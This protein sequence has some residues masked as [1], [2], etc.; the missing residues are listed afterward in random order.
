MCLVYSSS[1]LQASS[2]HTASGE[3]EEEEEDKNRPAEL[4]QLMDTLRRLRP[5]PPSVTAVVDGCNANGETTD[6]CTETETADD[7]PPPPDGKTSD[8]DDMETRLR[9]Y[10]DE[11]FEQLERRLE[12]RLEEL[13]IARFQSKAQ[14]TIEHD[15]QL[16]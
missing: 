12:K 8:D 2:G 7:E 11:K 5:P 10:I 6:G 16:D 9:L 15:L 13:L 3:E 1:G 14:H 4:S